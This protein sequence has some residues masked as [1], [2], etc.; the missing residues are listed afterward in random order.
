MRGGGWAG[1]M[2][3][4]RTA[5]RWGKWIR[6]GKARFQTSHRGGIIGCTG[7]IHDAQPTHLL[8]CSTAVLYGPHDPVAYIQLEIIEQTTL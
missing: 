6:R 3:E 8:C 7:L 5:Q 4:A 1:V 2:N